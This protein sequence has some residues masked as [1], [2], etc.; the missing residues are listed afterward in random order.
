MIRMLKN[1]REGSFSP[2]CSDTVADN[3]RCVHNGRIWNGG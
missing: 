2:D 3:T 1:R